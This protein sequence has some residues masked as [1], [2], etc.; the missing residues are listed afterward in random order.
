MNIRYISPQEAAS[1]L[2]QGA[3]LVD[4]RETDEYRREHIAAARHQALSSPV[5]DDLPLSDGQAVIFYCKSGMRTRH[6]AGRLA[7]AAGERPVFI[8][9]G[10]IEEWKKAGLPVIRDTS[11]PLELMRQVQIA[12]GSLVLLGVILGCLVSPVFYF[13][14]A[15]VGTG[16][17]FA[18]ISGFCGLAR[19]LQLMPWNRH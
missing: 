6:A 18:G 3:L 8:M 11:Q 1:L 10:G 19:L 12:A 13:L 16:L 5:T 15:F 9:E 4:I 17:V 2:E 14:P 7:S